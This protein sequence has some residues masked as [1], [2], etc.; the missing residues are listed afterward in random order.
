[1]IFRKTIFVL[2]LPLAL[3]LP[4]SAADGVSTPAL[5]YMGTPTVRAPEQDAASLAEDRG[6]ENNDT[7][8]SDCFY[9]QN[10]N[11]P[12]CVKSSQ[13]QAPSETSSTPGGY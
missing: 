8:S 1:M 4:A 5:Q 3:S 2:A 11:N 12:D 10:D 7:T 6:V 13:A 9:R